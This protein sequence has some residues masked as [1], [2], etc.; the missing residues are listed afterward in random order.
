MEKAIQRGGRGVARTDLME[1]WTTLDTK[2]KEWREAAKTWIQQYT[3]R[4]EGNRTNKDMGRHT[5]T[6]QK[7][8]RTKLD[9]LN[10]RK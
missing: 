10:T 6:Q 7:T 3:S 4:P 8:N 2:T 5:R 1:R 9:T